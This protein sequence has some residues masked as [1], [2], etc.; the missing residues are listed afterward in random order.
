MVK[1]EEMQQ[2][3]MQVVHMDR[4]FG[5]LESQFIGRPLQV[6]A[7]KP[8]PAANMVKALMWWSRPMMP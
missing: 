2:G 7:L 3:R 1:P 4:A 5:H 8:P 6:A